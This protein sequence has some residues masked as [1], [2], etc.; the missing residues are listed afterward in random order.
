MLKLI[1]GKRGLLANVLET[2]I[3][4][5]GDEVQIYNN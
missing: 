5:K 1:I 2:G 4:R 3:I